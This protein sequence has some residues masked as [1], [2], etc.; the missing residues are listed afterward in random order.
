MGAIYAFFVSGPRS[1]QSNPNSQATIL[2][3]SLHVN[4]QIFHAPT[5]VNP[6]VLLPGLHTNAQTFYGPVIARAATLVESL[7][8]NTQTF[9]APQLDQNITAGFHTN[10]QTFYSPSVGV[11]L[12]LAPSFH[13]NAQTFYAPSIGLN[14]T[15]ARHTNTQSFFAP[16]ISQGPTPGQILSTPSLSKTSSDPA[17]LE[18]NIG[19]GADIWAGHYLRIQRSLDGVKNASDGSY[20]NKTLECIHMIR[21]SEVAVLAITDADLMQ[22]GYFAPTGAGSQIYRWEREDGAISAWA[23]LSYNVTAPVATWHILNGANKNINC[24][25]DGLSW[26]CLNVGA[27]HGVRSTVPKSGKGHVEFEIDGISPTGS[28]R[29]G[30]VDGS[31]AIGPS[32]NVIVGQTAST[33]PVPG[34]TFAL[35]ANGSWTCYRNGGTA[36]GSLGVTPVAGDVIVCEFDTATNVVKFYFHDTSADTDTLVTTQTL[37]SPRIPSAWHGYA[38]GFRGGDSGTANFGQSAFVMTP[39]SGYAGW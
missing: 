1:Q 26:S 21:P 16:L 8:T 3:P 39:T 10:S 2:R 23:E 17:A 15:A 6:R 18:A 25:V 24:S 11:G 37:A 19:M 29:V 14:L 5:L 9:Y 33:L 36:T 32:A 7:H 27:Q 12:S 34:C 22:D 4:S 20:A 35:S 30:V 13:T 28:I 31:F 38:G